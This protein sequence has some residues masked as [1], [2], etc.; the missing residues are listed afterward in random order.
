MMKKISMTPRIS[1]SVMPRRRADAGPAGRGGV[2][3]RGVMVGY[4]T[5]LTMAFASSRSPLAA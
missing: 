3:G 1:S 4:S 5:Q 2:A